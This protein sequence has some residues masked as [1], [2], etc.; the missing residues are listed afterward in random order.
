[1]EAEAVEPL[2]EHFLAIAPA[3][4]E[5]ATKV[6]AVHSAPRA[7]VAAPDNFRA[8]TADVEDE[9]M[10]RRFVEQR[11]AA[12]ERQP[13]LLLGVD[14][15]E[16]EPG[17][18]LHAR[19]ELVTVDRLAAGFRRDRAKPKAAI[20][21]KP[22]GA[23]AQRLDGPAHGAR[24]QAPARGQALAQAHDAREGFDDAKPATLRRRDQQPAIVGAEVE[25]GI[26]L[27]SRAAFRLGWRGGRRGLH[28]PKAIL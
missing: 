3:V 17:F 5:V 14:D 12:G 21:R 27:R 24:R 9:R 22:A 25:R 23:D 26:G 15:L 10:R 16:R 19:D 8:A 1:M 6:V 11:R 2:R 20:A 4:T 28:D 18:A 7:D 13:G